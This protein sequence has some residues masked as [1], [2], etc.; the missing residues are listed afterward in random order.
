MRIISFF[1]HISLALQQV[2]G[3]VGFYGANRSNKRENRLSKFTTHLSLGQKAFGV[4]GTLLRPDFHVR[5]LTVGQ[6]RVQ[7]TSPK[8]R[9][10]SDDPLFKEE[11]MCNET[12]VGSGQIWRYGKDIFSSEADAQA[13]LIVL[14]QKSHKQRAQLGC[15]VAS[16]Y[17]K[18]Y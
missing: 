6:I 11:Y 5:T 3:Q 9:D 7:V 1:W 15:M 18:K 17:F 12:G 14:E 16:R 2:C 10:W 8:T 4:E 13:A